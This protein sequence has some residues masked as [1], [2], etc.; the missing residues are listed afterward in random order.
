MINLAFP[1][2]F[3]SSVVVEGSRGAEGE[4]EVRHKEGELE[5]KADVEREVQEVY[6]TT[7]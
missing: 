1:S 7:R 4:V 6:C 3:E 2:P 5:A